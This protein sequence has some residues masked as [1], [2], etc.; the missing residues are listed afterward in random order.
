MA[1]QC[2]AQD[3]RGLCALTGD[4]HLQSPSPPAPHS[5]LGGGDT[6]ELVRSGRHIC[7]AFTS[8]STR[9]YGNFSR[10]FGRSAVCPRCPPR[11]ARTN[12]R[13]T[14]ARQKLIKFVIIIFNAIIINITTET[15]LPTAAIQNSQPMSYQNP[16]DVEFSRLSTQIGANIELLSKNVYT[17]QRLVN[18]PSNQTQLLKLQHTTNLLAR[19]TNSLI[20]DL[21]QLPHP[22]NPSE[23]RQRNF[24]R[25]RLT[26][27]FS[28]ALRNFQVVQ[29][30]IKAVEPI[31]TTRSVTSGATGD[32][33]HVLIDL[34]QH[35]D[36][37]TTASASE[38][39]Q[40]QQQE[41]SSLNI[42]ELREREESVRKLEHDI[43]EVN[44][45]FKDLAT[46][47]HN[48]GET[49]DSIESSI[50]RATEEVSRGAQEIARARDYQDRS[51]R[52]KFYLA[53]IFFIIMF[54]VL[55]VIYLN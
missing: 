45:I 32:S 8:T 24:M 13:V 25:D 43:V 52:K 6:V 33:S 5:K 9:A 4:C 18:Q 46:I 2:S 44:H 15:I 12:R 47:I 55:L 53:M 11:V 48:Q 17:M 10:H 36:G 16:T 3:I 27:D 29:R 37:E 39:Q 38:N 30:A 26:N 20:K 14:A 42:D 7:R 22:A 23:R 49:V 41:Q 1:L 31:P 50:F 28:E 19:D 35:Q 34:A 54:I 21:T 40:L 51:R